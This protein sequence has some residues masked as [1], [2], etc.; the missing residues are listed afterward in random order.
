MNQINQIKLYLTINLQITFNLMK[1][2]MF[3]KSWIFKSMRYIAT[4][5]AANIKKLF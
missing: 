3:L 2:C 1:L 4:A 5:S